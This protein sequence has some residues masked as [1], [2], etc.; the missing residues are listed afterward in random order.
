MHKILQ[1]A[2][3]LLPFAVVFF[4][5]TCS[6]LD[7]GS[8][9]LNEKVSCFKPDV[10][11]P[12]FSSAQPDTNP[13][14][15]VLDYVDL[16]FSEEVKNGEDVN[17]Y[18]LPSTGGAS[19][20]LKIQSVQ[21]IAQYTYRVFL[22]GA[23]IATGAIHIDFS[24]IVDYNGNFLTG[25]NYVDYTGSANVPITMSVKYLGTDVNGVSNNGGGAYSN[26]DISFSHKFTAD[27]A[28]NYN[29]YLTTGATTCSGTSLGSG[30]NLAA[31]V[32]I[33]PINRV[34]SLFPQPINRIVVCIANQNN[35]TAVGTASWL[36]YRDDTVPTVTAS[37]PP[38]NF[39]SPV[40][41]SLTCA[42]A[43]PDR[44]A[45]TSL[46]QQNSAPG[47]PTAPGF[48]AVGVINPTSNLYTGPITATNP[49]NP[50]YTRF[51]WQCIDKAG[52]RSDIAT[53]TDYQYYVDSTIPAVT[54]VNDATFRAYIGPANTST[55]IKF[56]TDQLNKT[57]Y[58]MRNGTTCTNGGDGI[59]IATGS[60]GT[61][62]S[63]IQNP[64]NTTTHFTAADAVYPVRICVAGP[65]AIWGTAFLYITT[66][67]T[68][69]VISPTVSAGTYSAVQ[70]VT[71]NCTDTNLDKAA[72]RISTQLGN[73][74]PT[75]A[76]APTFNPAT[77]A[78]TST[79]TLTGPY[80]TPDS[81]TTSAAYGCID[82]AGNQATGGTVQYTIDSTVPA[83][84]LAGS[85]HIGA[86]INAGGY[87]SVNI[88]WNT[89]QPGANYLSG[90][91]FEIRSSADCVSGTILASGLSS[92]TPNA[93]NVT[94]IPAAT[95][96]AGANNI[97]ICVK[98]Y[99]GA[100]GYQ[101]AA[102]TITRDDALPTFAGI[103]SVVNPNDGT[104]T[105]NWVAG[106][107]ALSGL[108]G[109]DV[110]QSTVASPGVGSCTA[111]FVSTYQ[112][113]SGATSFT[114][115]G[116]NPAATYYFM[117]RARD[118]AGNRDANVVERK[119]RLNLNI[120]T[121][122]YVG[123]GTLQIQVNGA[124]T[125]SISGNGTQTFTTVFNGGN[126]YRLAIL[127]QPTGQ[128][129]A[130]KELQFG[131]FTTDVTL[132]AACATGSLVGGRFQALSTAPLT[133]RLY[134]GKTSTIASG[135][136]SNPE[137]IAYLGGY[138][139]LAD[140]SN[141]VIKKILA[142]APY[143]V[144]T[145]TSTGTAAN[146]ATDDSTSCAS[147][148]FSTISAIHSDGTNLYV[149]EWGNGR[150]RKVSDVASAGC[151]V[152]TLAG[153][154][155]AGFVDGAPSVARF[156]TVYQIVSDGSYL[157]VV[158]NGNHRVRRIRLDSGSVDTIAGSAAVGSADNANGL[159]ATFD[160]LVAL[161]LS[162]TDL[163][164][165]EY[166]N[167]TIRKISLSTTG[168]P[169]T[170]VAGTAG[171]FGQ[172]DAK[173]LNARMGRAISMTAVGSNIYF[174][175]FLYNTL[176]RLDIQNGY[177]ITTIAGNGAASSLDGTGASATFNNPHGITTDGRNLY[178]VEYTGN[179]VRKV[180]DN[181]LVGYW[182]L[183]GLADEYS[184][185]G[186]FAKNGTITGNV[187]ATSGRYSDGGGGYFFDGVSDYITGTAGSQADTNFN[188]GNFTI[189]FWIKPAATQ[190]ESDGAP[191]DYDLVSNWLG[192]YDFAIRYHNEIA[193]GATIP[194]NTPAQITFIRFDGTLSPYCISGVRIDDGKF[195]HVTAQKSGTLLHL[196]I[197]GK[198]VCTTNDT[199]GS[200][201][202]VG[203]VVIGARPGS[204]INDFT[205]TLA[206]MRL[207]NR[208]LN[209]GEINELAQDALPAEA[210]SAFNNG[211]TGL[212][213]HY[214]FTGGALADAG[215]LNLPLGNAGSPGT[216]IGKDGE[217]NGSFVFT[218]PGD[219]LLTN[220][221]KGLP[222][223]SHPRS[224]CV[225]VKPATQPAYT[226][227]RFPIV[228]YGDIGG[229]G[230]FDLVYYNAASS[231][232][233][234][235]R[236]A[237]TD[238]GSII[239]ETAI[240]LELN[241][242]QHL[243]LTNNGAQTN[244]YRDGRNIFSGG[245]ALTGPSALNRITIATR[246]TDVS[247]TFF[248]K[249]DDVRIYN[250]ALTA[251]QVRQL[252]TQVPG[253]LLARTDFTGDT[254]DASGWAQN[255]S[256]SGSAPTA[257]VDRFLIGGNAYNFN[258]S[259]RLQTAAPV[260]TK[261]DDVSLT[262]WFRVTAFSSGIHYVIING[263][264]GDGYGVFIDG[265]AGNVMKGILGGLG[266]LNTTYV[267]PLNVWT[268]I[269]MMRTSGT[270]SILVNGAPLSLTG[271][272]ITL[273]TTPMAPLSGTYIGGD[274]GVFDYLTGDIDDA[275]VYNR[276]LS[277]AE[278]RALAGYHPMQISVWNSNPVSSALKMHLIPDALGALSNN[279]PIPAWNDSSGNGLNVAQGTLAD[280]PQ[281]SAA[282]INNRPAV[283]FNSNRHF[284]MACN[285]N[286]TSTA[287]TML[288]VMNQTNTS[289]GFRG[290]FHHGDKLLYFNGGSPT[291]QNLSFFQT[292]PDVP[293]ALSQNMY[294]SLINTNPNMI[295][296]VSH[297][298]ANGYIFKNGTDVTASSSIITGFSCA[299]GLTLGKPAW[300]GDNFNG[301]MGDF[302]YF[303]AA[304]TN[305]DR[306]IGECYLSAKYAIPL[307]GICP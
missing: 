78:I 275:R 76:T 244:L 185:D 110:C 73:I 68:A 231:G 20:G 161:A 93:N 85:D 154:G 39:S 55:T 278:V 293:R 174:V 87:T 70:S 102:L 290:I 40:N 160:G 62:G 175:D 209:E 17:A 183:N 151:S 61:P 60:T 224:V 200:I 245:S 171:A 54:L 25:T 109:Y 27:N 18:T 114:V 107:D 3:A 165:G 113:A 241:I 196:F 82:L 296:G 186:N 179:R 11:A 298:G 4:F 98:N 227:A 132:N 297:T 211:A 26:V 5:V 19:N 242:W 145:L 71:F 271:A 101:T 80:N 138:L 129:C 64:F 99:A 88:T 46:L 134:Q 206:D 112:A 282:G 115:T 281:F 108:G 226:P 274:G 221:P 240:Q 272:G 31:N 150:I 194:A 122:G 164:V 267:P 188:G 266:Y 38:D 180:V 261:L 301:L 178:V 284:T 15:T 8:N 105:L 35:P 283:N 260:T 59:Q 292:G 218:N 265:N 238:N 43:N 201:T 208:V 163:Y 1:Y 56:S 28:N 121:T 30:T 21:K 149:A 13:S 155:T 222:L 276:A 2:Y 63:I 66:D 57:Y 32:S 195:H 189:A 216:A 104:M 12:R 65:T 131:S 36:I 152:T 148:R 223:L 192:Q 97:K 118:Q 50:T 264:G 295:F 210:G 247:K 302:M 249:V 144:T 156:D 130:I 90:S 214:Q 213:S 22:G 24:K 288:G 9:C 135:S 136:F 125:L 169:V 307:A 146:N 48:D 168:F 207:Y 49:A 237:L 254:S 127:T 191:R 268:H 47:L 23:S 74:S 153:T 7:T 92:A 262:A 236:L 10:T 286:L 83:V 6:K 140:A 258:G 269:A 305:S 255:I 280:Q 91:N 263:D 190:L 52:N 42:D 198:K 270:W 230:Y 304:L 182:P 277:P 86:T 162:G 232:A 79:M 116:L 177:N 158:D 44:I 287:T 248:G 243:C 257:T 120:V 170:T 300:V 81:S 253:G 53:P 233:N 94:T 279:N 193:S 294:I 137:N 173:G 239:H 259:G 252:S 100:I 89:S 229:G 96:P 16:T 29:I 205:G 142:T 172:V 303:D 95:F 117:V 111:S 69:P 84:T 203:P 58:I 139:Y 285:I 306:L 67:S 220:A 246:I 228:S 250:N 157:Y 126:P 291:P 103:T 159:L 41:I 77:G 256:P 133:Y 72:Y 123:P 251:L 167:P 119:S 234:D 273:T 75:P 184:S 14:Y 124:E 147:A 37:I 289:G 128:I 299:T 217:P 202:N 181:G 143:T 219:F 199:V 225:F 106:N 34:A 215:A 166:N 51:R 141:H 187:S 176:R 197:D 204:T 33:T 212:L 235:Y 45:Y